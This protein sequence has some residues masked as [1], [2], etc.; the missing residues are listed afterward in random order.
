M[1]RYLSLSIY[2]VYF[3]IWRKEIDLFRCIS[4][5]RAGGARPY[6]F[7]CWLPFRYQS[8]PQHDTPMTQRCR[9]RCSAKSTQIAAHSC[10][11]R[12]SFIH[13]CDMTH[14]HMWCDTVTTQRCQRHCSARSTQIAAHSYKRRHSFMCDKTHLYMWHGSAMPS[15]L[16]RYMVC[17][18]R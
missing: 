4:D 14:S 6:Q 3:F 16:L 11:R 13:M 17:A 7:H 10:M 5:L 8:N 1:Y 15:S 12:D 18:Q 2:E 9:R